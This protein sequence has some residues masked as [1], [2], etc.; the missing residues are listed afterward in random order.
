VFKETPAKELTET[1]CYSR[2]LLKTVA[3]LCYFH[4]VHW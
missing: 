4:F 1:N 3:N 2:Q